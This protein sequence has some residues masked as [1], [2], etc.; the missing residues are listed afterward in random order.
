MRYS[1]LIEVRE[2]KKRDTVKQIGYDHVGTRLFVPHI[3]LVY[4]FAIRRGIKPFQ[5][6]RSIRTISNPHGDLAFVY[7]GLQQKDTSKGKITVLKVNASEDFREFRYR[8]Y[9]AVKDMIL[10]QPQTHQFNS[11][12]QD[13]FWFH[14]TIAMRSGLSMIQRLKEALIPLDKVQSEVERI[15]LLKSQRIVY[16]YDLN[17]DRILSR[18]QALSRNQI[19]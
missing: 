12:P 9:Q 10:E 17:A 2:T 8:L 3:T 18:S 14:A 4:P 13:R 11:L 7:D 19:R 16:E 15:S 5:I 6:M 1:W